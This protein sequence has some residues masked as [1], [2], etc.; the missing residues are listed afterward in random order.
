MTLRKSRGNS[1]EYHIRDELRKRGFKA[2]KMGGNT[3]GFP[4]IVATRHNTILAIEAK[5]VADNLAYVPIDEIQRCF[6]LMDMFELYKHKHAI[7]AFKFMTKINNISFRRQ[8][9]YY[10]YVMDEWELKLDDTYKWV[11]CDYLG[12]VMLITKD[13]ELI[14]LKL[15]HVT[16]LKDDIAIDNVWQLQTKLTP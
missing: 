12:N 16:F 6:D 13:K 10:Y 5:S 15:P 8:L 4:D 11:R 1:F 2:N 14:K 9:R 7:V 3:V